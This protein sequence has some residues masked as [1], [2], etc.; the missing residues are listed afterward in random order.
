MND[1]EST[2]RRVNAYLAE[3]GSRLSIDWDGEII[4]RGDPAWFHVYHDGDD[5]PFVVADT[6]PS[7][8]L[9]E[10]AEHREHCERAET[11]SYRGL[12]EALRALDSEGHFQQG[13]EA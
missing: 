10:I 4:G 7:F 5:T 13:S 3:A 9:H 11:V 8:L 1:P 6:G 2:E 12:V